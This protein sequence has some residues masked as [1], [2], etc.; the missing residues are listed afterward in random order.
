[1]SEQQGAEPEISERSAKD[2]DY[3]S[4]VELAKERLDHEFDDNDARATRVILTLNRAA[5]LVTYDLESSIHRPR[6]GSW[7]AFRMMFVL[8]LA[9]PMEPNV[10][11][12]LAGMSRAAVSNLA[13]TLVA[14]GLLRK[15]A[16][17]V[18]GR[19]VTLTLTD[20]G[21]AEIRDIFREQNRRET[22]WASVLTDIEQDL[23]VMLLEKLMSQREQVGAKAR[24]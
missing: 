16:A 24:N 12:N 11:A 23:L 9:G 3:W 17:A 20:A 5:S 6:G 22:S 18:D 8:W 19:A 14:R 15:D 10:A 21:L 1:M 13:K 2:L 7:S 4:F